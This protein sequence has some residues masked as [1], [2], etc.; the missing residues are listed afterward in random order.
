MSYQTKKPQEGP[1][2][3]YNRNPGYDGSNQQFFQCRKSGRRRIDNTLDC[4]VHCDEHWEKLLAD[5]R[6]RSW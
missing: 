3:S 1:C 4:G 2:E 5:C 6:K